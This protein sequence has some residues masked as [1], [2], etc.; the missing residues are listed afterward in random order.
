MRL[1]IDI[2]NT[3]LKWTSQHDGR[4]SPADA[5]VHDQ[6]NLENAL[7]VIWQDLDTPQ[8]VWVSSVADARV[9]EIVDRYLI[10]HWGRKPNYIRSSRAVLGVT[11][12][13]TEPHK[14]GSDR[15][16]AMVAA[17][18]HE[19]RCVMIVDC[20]SAVTIDAVNDDGEHLGGA[21]AP[22]ITLGNSVLTR[23]TS[24]R[25]QQA[26]G[27]LPAKIFANSTTDGIAS[28]IG[29]G[30]I[31]LIEKAYRELADTGQ[32]PVV[33]L[34]GGDAAFISHALSI[35]HKQVDDLVLQGLAMLANHA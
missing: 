14:L 6:A 13:Y 31:G 8:D 26:T 1:L 5:I 25:W 7:P 11:N 10:S 22:G 33:Y 21:I 17:F 34:T 28:G 30:I 27:M 15:W 24:L 4:L 20:G 2:G 32:H 23:Q 3:R 35:E 16:L 9:N 19:G 18:Q 29:Y 12:S